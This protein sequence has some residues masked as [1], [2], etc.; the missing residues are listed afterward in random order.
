MID[1]GGYQGL[2]IKIAGG[3]AVEPG[4]GFSSGVNTLVEGNGHRISITSP[5]DDYDKIAVKSIN[6][7]GDGGNG[8]KYILGG[9]G[10]PGGKGGN[11]SDTELTVYNL[12]IDIGHPDKKINDSTAILAESIG[13]KG[14]NGGGSYTIAA[15]GG[16]GNAGGAG[17]N[18]IIKVDNTKIKI[19]GDNASGIAA[20][21]SGGKGGHGGAS[22]GIIAHGGRGDQAGVAGDVDITVTNSQ[23]TID[24][25][26]STGILAQSVAGAGGNSGKSIGV[27]SIGGQGGSGGDAGR[28]AVNSAAN[29]TMTGTGSSA[30]VAQSIGGGGGNGGLTAAVL[31]LGATGGAGGNSGKVSVTN[32]GV[33]STAGDYAHGISAQSIGGGGGN[34][35]KAFGLVGIGG[36][37]K[38]AGKGA[39]VIVNN[40]HGADIST[41][42]LD[43]YGIVAQSIGGGGNS[44]STA[45]VFAIGGNGGKGNDASVVTVNNFANIETGS[46]NNKNNES[47]G[48]TAILAQ[49][50]GGGGGNG[51]MAIAAGLSFSLAMGGEGAQGGNADQVKVK[52]GGNNGQK[53]VLS[54]CGTNS[55]AIKAQSI[56]GGGNGGMAIAANTGI[57]GASVSLGGEAGKGG[58]SGA[59]DVNTSADTIIHTHGDRS[60]AITAQSIGGSGGDGGMSIAAEYTAGWGAIIS[61]GGKGA[62]GGQSDQVSIL[63]QAKIITE[64]TDST[65]LL[66]QSIGGSG[67]SG[68]LA[69]AAAAGAVNA[70][71]AL[72]GN[73]DEGGKSAD[74]IIN[75]AGDIETLG[76]SSSAIVSQSIGGSGGHAGGAAAVSVGA[77]SVAV[78]LGAESGVGGEAAQAKVSSMGNLKTTGNNATAIIAQSIG[79][80][81]GNA[82][83]SLAGTASGIAGAGISLGGKAEKGGKAGDV[84]AQLSSALDKNLTVEEQQANKYVILTQGDNSSG[85]LAQSIGGS[86]GNAGTAI[87]INA[88]ANITGGGAFGI[89]LGDQGGQGGTAGKVNV[90]SDHHIITKGQNASAIVA[91]SVGG[92]GGN[93][94]TSVAATASASLKGAVTATI[95]IGG[96]AG[97]G[98]AANTVTVKNSGHIITQ[99]DH[100][101]GIVAQSI[102]GNGGNGGTA[103]AGSLTLSPTASVAL[104]SSVSGDG[105]T[106]GLSKQVSV[107]NEGD[108]ITDGDFSSGILA[109]SILG[110]GGAAGVS[111]A[112][113][114]AVS[115]DKAFSATVSL[116]GK[117]GSVAQGAQLDNNVRVNNTNSHLQTKGHF[118]DG[119]SAQAIGGNGGHA[120]ITLGAA[121]SGGLNLAGGVAVGVGGEGGDGGVGGKVTVN[122]SHS[123]IVTMGNSSN[124]INAQSIGGSGGNGGLSIAGSI[125]IAKDTALGLS[126]SVGGKA[127]KGNASSA[128]EVTSQNQDLIEQ[129]SSFLDYLKD[130]EQHQYLSSIYTEGNSSNGILAQAIGGGGGNGGLAGS[131]ALAGSLDKALTAAVALGGS[132]N[133]GGTGAIVKVNSTDNITTIGQDSNAI[134][135]QSIGG[136][137]GN[138]GSAVNGVLSAGLGM[139]GG[140]YGVN[141]S[142]G[143]Q[144]GEGNRADQVRVESNGTLVTQGHSSNGVL[145]QSIGGGGGTGGSVEQATVAIGGGALE[146]ILSKLGVPVTTA[147]GGN[148]GAITIDNVIGADIFTQKADSA[149]IVAQSIAGG[150][151]IGG[152]ATGTLSL[153]GF[154]SAAGQSG[155][156]KVSNH[157]NLWT[158][159]LNSAA[160]IAQSIGGGG[161]IGGNA[162]SA[163]AI[164]GFAGAAGQSGKVSID[165]HGQVKTAEDHS[166][167][168]LAQ[169]IAGGGGVGGHAS[170]KVAIG[171]FGASGSNS[172]S[173][174][175]NNAGNLFTLGVNAS[176]I[177][178]QSI[179]GGGGK[180]GLV[181]VASSKHQTI[182]PSLK[183]LILLWVVMVR[184]QVMQV[185]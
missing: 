90:V 178:A 122:N 172:D 124:G 170:G 16:S 83:F 164:G 77:V 89:A 103:L 152:N 92:S 130:P 6:K 147:N 131:F 8:G 48:S 111:G 93:G 120:G 138:A 34:A 35:G 26:H 97:A 116:G 107:E 128:V 175:V 50:I 71:F 165:N 3:T 24:G 28:A 55:S 9:K 11:A 69:V 23:I 46:K 39:D 173:V 17:A 75:N 86:G 144:G 95:A 183:V 33:L 1:S 40:E 67:G 29:I 171:G 180:G 185:K 161:G 56:G 45:G 100:S 15:N 166:T 114:A 148:G 115:G 85:V 182:R 80:A 7:G 118:S 61:L 72:G 102:G 177:V 78:A 145:A 19:W 57:I 155:E 150:G 139:N 117:G 146:N 168:L 135:A 119:I 5:V 82:G 174:K 162:S 65:G 142:L 157:A 101:K 159:G 163:L 49:S 96:A 21:S 84:E 121:L 60:T 184:V 108:I 87:A 136:G 79:G 41:N 140:S 32:K 112:L 62:K 13:G 151:G 169:S 43:A 176:A 63:N 109:Q 126:A 74:V 88:N 10:K 141:V 70:T 156:V 179:S 99:G 4:S 20:I 12:N 94:G 58:K 143:G 22:G 123:S 133:T 158:E 18:A 76:E 132:G 2:E 149:A 167:A 52:V 160:I 73:G 153:G 105:G 106:S 37:G 25:N 42:G 54:T 47:M 53:T 66:A 113:S 68:G 44:G 129:S 98:V 14:G 137:G 27:A 134:L 104:S 30:I 31:S 51:S 110:N 181:M 38:G 91:Q 81:G 59:V 125:A 127:G 154:G 64:G 36:D